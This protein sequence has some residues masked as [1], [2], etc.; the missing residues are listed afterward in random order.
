MTVT[1]TMIINDAD[2]DDDTDNDMDSDNDNDND[3]NGD[4]ASDIP[5]QICCCEMP[6]HCVSDMLPTKQPSHNR[7]SINDDAQ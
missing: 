1:V 5:E 6:A 3:N 7:N 2:N 4:N